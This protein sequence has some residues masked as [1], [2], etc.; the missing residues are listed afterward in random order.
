MWKQKTAIFI[1]SQ[2]LSLFGS[3]L[4][5]YALLWYV[6]L[7]TKSGLIMALYIVCGFVPTFILSPFGGVWAD[8]YERKKLIMLSDG[9]IALITLV[10]AVVFMAGEKSLWLIMLAAGF[11]AVGTAVQGPAVGAILP[12][13]VPA[14]HLTK[15]NGI[16]GSIQSA[17]M[18]VSPIASGALI[19]FQPMHTVFFIDV[20]TAALAIATLFFFLDVPPHEK[21]GERQK[22]TYFTDMLLGFRYIQ[23]HRYLISFFTFLGI[24]LFLA[25]PAAFLTPLQVVRSFGSDV[26]RLT[27][28]EIVFS[29]GMMLGGGLISVWGGFNNRT[30]TMVLATGVMAVCTIALGMADVFWL[31]LVF[32]GIFGVALPFFTTPSTVFIQEHVEE[33]F[34]GRVFSVNTMLFTSVMPLG[35]LVFGPIVEAVRIEPIL[36]I[37]G[38]LM[39]IQ[40]LAVLWNKKLIRA[41]GMRAGEK[42]ISE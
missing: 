28:I 4:V 41:G 7:E 13:F 5:Q 3:S 10:L 33:N 6:T 15:I 30:Y 37:T 19:T 11:R 38:L 8:R 34:L 26:W 1:I 42:N 9:L 12:Q 23:E 16:S 24:L 31:Y 14:E 39:L 32:M 22:T 20:V 40:V 17:I 36:V 25:T 27:A 21:A 35:M 2:S 29:T 18:L